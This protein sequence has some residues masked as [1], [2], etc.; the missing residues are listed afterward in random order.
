MCTS[1]GHSKKGWTDGEIGRAWIEDFDNKT[2]EKTNG[3]RRVLLVDGHNSHYTVDFLFY[4]R[5]HD[6]GVLCYPSHCTH[7][8]QG[9]DVVIFSPLKKYWQQERDAEER[10]HGRKVSKSN[11]LSVYARA[12]NRALTPKNIQAAFKKTGVYPF[13]PSVITPDMLAPA[14][15]TAIEHR[16][17]VPLQTPVRVLV[18]AFTKLERQRRDAQNAR[19]QGF[20]SDEE[21]VPDVLI[22]A[23]THLSKKS[24]HPLFTD[25]PLG[26]LTTPP[27]FNANM[28]SPIK[29]H[30]D[31]LQV[32]PLTEREKLLQQAL[33]DCEIREAELKGEIRGQQAALVLQ[34]HYCERLR[35]EIHGVEE[36]RKKK[37]GNT[38]IKIKDI[39]QKGRLLTDDKLIA[40][41]AQHHAEIEVRATEKEK[42]KTLRDKHSDA[43]RKWKDQEEKRKQ[44]CAEIKARY[45]AEMEAWKEE[46]ELAQAEKRRSHLKKPVRGPLPKAAPKPKKESAVVDEESGE[47]FDDVSNGSSGS[48]ME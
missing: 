20:L 27:R 28:V 17:I 40:L 36:K 7:I 22:S 37:D 6:I 32:Q 38:A 19:E 15:E 26:S 33:Q 34:N 24:K 16:A 13:D 39:N 42:R 2:K 1:L 14:R 48:D 18:G 41:Y 10:V 31:L 35:N 45:A 46:K 8:Y 12:H 44:K 25:K 30:G 43:I 11:F 47:E 3:R 4:A 23:F 21:D 29:R 9:L 5:D